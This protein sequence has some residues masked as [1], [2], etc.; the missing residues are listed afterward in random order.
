MKL[1]KSVP[2]CPPTAGRFLTAATIAKGSL[3][4]AKITV[5]FGSIVKT[6]TSAAKSP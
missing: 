6:A 3:P 2:F 1:P 5:S 4:Y